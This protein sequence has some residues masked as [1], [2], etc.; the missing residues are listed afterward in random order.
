MHAICSFHDVRPGAA[1]R[2]RQRK[3]GYRWRCRKITSAS[4]CFDALL[5]SQ[6]GT[7]HAFGYVISN[8]WKFCSSHTSFAALLLILSNKSTFT[9]SSPA[10]G[11]T[12]DIT[13]YIT[14][15]SLRRRRRTSYQSQG[16]II[17]KELLL[18]IHYGW[19]IC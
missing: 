12:C 15:N 10:T 19:K 17:A 2:K 5:P 8:S 18:F 14:T 4:A 16:Y 11:K 9:Q 6:S 1:G 7:V 13:C 3:D